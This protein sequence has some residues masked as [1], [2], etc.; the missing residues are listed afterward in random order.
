MAISDACEQPASCGL[1]AGALQGMLLNWSWLCFVFA[2]LL[3]LCVRFWLLMALLVAFCRLGQ[4][5][6][7]LER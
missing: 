1:V 6:N 4:D 3:F 2:C 5:K 7:R